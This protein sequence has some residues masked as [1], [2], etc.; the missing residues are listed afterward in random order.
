MIRTCS[1]DVPT[2]VAHEVNIPQCCPV[3]ANPAPG[4]VI[5]VCYIPNGIV[6]PVENLVDLVNEYVGG[7]GDVRNMEEMI[8]DVASRV[9]GIVK[10]PVR[11]IADLNIRPPF[12]GDMQKMRVSAR[13][14]A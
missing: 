14:R 12:G 1:I 10:V 5:K 9:A 4:S 8:Q 7:R 6:Y 3:S 13:A 11:A 2:F